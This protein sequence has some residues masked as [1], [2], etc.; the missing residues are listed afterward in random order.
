M[1]LSNYKRVGFA[2]LKRLVRNSARTGRALCVIGSPGM[3]K[4][5]MAGE[6]A[7]HIGRAIVEMDIGNKPKE[8]H[9]LP[10]TVDRDGEK[11]VVYVPSASLLRACREPVLLFIDEVTR[12]DKN[13]F[14]VA[15]AIAH[16]RQL[17]DYQLHPETVVLFAGNGTDSGG[18]YTPP[19]AFINRVCMVEFAPSREEGLEVI[20]RLTDFMSVKSEVAGEFVARFTAADEEFETAH[21]AMSTM[22]AGW[23]TQ[24]TEL[25]SAHPPEDAQDDCAPWASLR[26]IHHAIDRMAAFTADGEAIDEVAIAAAVGTIGTS[27]AAA[28]FACVRSAEK[29]PTIADV[30]KTPKTAKLPP[31]VEAA[32]AAFGI[33]KAVGKKSATSVW[34]YTERLAKQFPEFKAS[35]AK[36]ITGCVPTDPAAFAVFQLHVGVAN[37]LANRAR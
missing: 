16:E 32:V 26:A 24:R 2:A 10:V 17:G 6:C 12:A 34:L 11:I 33:L 21:R 19:E 14:A 35:F 8:D 18:T 37:D 9:I 7:R 22:Y 30:V 4:T 5:A 1:K 3:G 29:L 27:A 25:F 13:K 36:Q 31:D 28:L 23:A 20:G 15:M